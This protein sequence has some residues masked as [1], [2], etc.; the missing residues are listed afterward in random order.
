M[1]KK[2]GMVCLLMALV[3]V[4]GCAP[5]ESAKPAEPV[6]ITVWNYYNGA[7]L[8]AFNTLVAE[9]NQTRGKE[10]G[11]T[12]KASS[13]GSV[14][15]LETNVIA[16]AEKA[17]GAKDVPNIFA[18]YSDTAYKIDQMGLVADISPY[19]T[20]EEKA[21][22]IDSY[23]VEGDL[24][25]K[26]SIKI[27]PIAKST[28]IFILNLTDWQKFSDATGAK[29]SDMETIEGVTRTAEAYYNWT[30]AQTEMPNDGQALFGRDAMANYILVGARQL[31]VEIIS[32]DQD[33]NAVLNFPEETVRKLWDHYYVPFIKGHFSA[34]GR[35]RSD[36]VKT[37]NL[38]GFVGSSTSTSFFPKEVIH[39]DDSSYPIEHVVLM[40]PKFEGGQAYATQQGAGMVVT[41]SSEQTERAS[42]E[43][44][45]WFTE[46]ERNISFSLSS[47]YMPVKKEANDIEVIRRHASGETSITAALEVSIS[48]VTSNT[49][50]T[51]IATTNGATVRSI[52][53]YSMSDKAAA[54]R[55][56]IDALMAQGVSREEAIARFDTDDNFRAW[57][58]ATKAKLEA[59]FK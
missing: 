18:A 21:S 8:D 58:D 44:L 48:T 28:E 14:K 7:Q 53:E 17:V 49:M 29:L 19:F 25:G 11:I 2:L 47:A 56:E 5:R 16:A 3:L 13:E 46:T 4:T 12:V 38:I 6:E 24:D 37:G 57:Y 9:F 50:Y 23:L 39:S 40:A 52:L 20:A 54:D 26:N 41:R 45:K 32:T 43:F 10:L 22:Y 30:D 27:F 1:K 59:E 33:G 51:P 34:V 36:D 55:A 35:F 42:V 15:D 31:G